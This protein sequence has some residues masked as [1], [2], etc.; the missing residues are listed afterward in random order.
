MA[1]TSSGN[2]PGVALV[3]GASRGLGEA[4]TRGLVKAG[5]TVIVDARDPDA[6]NEAMDGIREASPPGAAVAVPGD[7]ADVTHRRALVA[8]AERAGGLDLLVN[9]AS[10]LGPSPLPA[11]TVLAPEDLEALLRT[12][13][14][15]PLALVQDVARLLRRSSHPM[16]VNITSDAS[17]EA[18]PGWG[19]YG[20]SKAALDQLSN[21]L[22]TEEPGWRVWWVDPGDLRTKMHQD[23]FPGEDISDRPAPGSVVPALLALVRSDR[24]SGRVRLREIQV[25]EAVEVGK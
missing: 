10:S 4:L 17:V 9:N 23:A 16:V 14:V 12:N 19:G 25:F 1:P 21:V 22:A 7:V 2:N 20:A 13:A 5:W 3:T 8:A 6:L 11:L 24:P 15:A 18:Y